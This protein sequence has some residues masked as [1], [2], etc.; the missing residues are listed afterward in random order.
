[1]KRYLTSILM[2]GS[3]G[4]LV[5]FVYYFRRGVDDYLT[6]SALAT[7]PSAKEIGDQAGRDGYISFGI[8]TVL[9]IAGTAMFITAV[10]FSRFW[11]KTTDR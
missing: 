7:M 2:L 6:C 9:A 3:T 11:S 4:A 1:M 5:L 8:C 10:K